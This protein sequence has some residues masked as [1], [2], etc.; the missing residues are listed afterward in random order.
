[1]DMIGRIRRLHS[2][3]RKSVREIARLTGPL[4]NT[5]AKWL[6]APVETAPKYR[7]GAVATKLLPF[8]EVLTLSLKADAR[9]PRHE[10]RTARALFEEIRSAG[11]DGGY[12]RVTDFVRAWRHGPQAYQAAAKATVDNCRPRVSP[13]RGVRAVARRGA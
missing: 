9:R 6:E 5:I 1:M 3:G 12:N 8:R 11:Y 10:R 7:R 4:R 2:R 13:R